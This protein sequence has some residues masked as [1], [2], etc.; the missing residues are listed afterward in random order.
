PVE[1]RNTSP[2]SQPAA[3]AAICAVNLQASRPVLPV[4]ALALPEFTTSTRV[5]LF[6]RCAR[7]HSTGADGHFERVNTP[8]AVVPGSNSASRTSVRPAERMTASAVARRT[9]ETAGMSGTLAGAR[10]ETAV[11]ITFSVVMSGFVPVSAVSDASA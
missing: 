6:F 9:P 3:R 8:A 7:H 2:G 4:N 10:G 11:D 1:A 5:L